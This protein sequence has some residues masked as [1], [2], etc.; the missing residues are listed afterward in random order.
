MIFRMATVA[1]LRLVQA[2]V[3]ANS[4]SNRKGQISTPRGSKMDIDETEYITMSQV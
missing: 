2:A 1:I 3:K 4:K